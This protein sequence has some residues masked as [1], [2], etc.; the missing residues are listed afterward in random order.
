VITGVSTFQNLGNQSC[1]GGKG[2][3][4]PACGVGR[5]ETT[6]NGNL[7]VKPPDAVKLGNLD[8]LNNG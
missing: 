8:C 7:G 1:I 4:D 6:G 2:F 5:G 3:E